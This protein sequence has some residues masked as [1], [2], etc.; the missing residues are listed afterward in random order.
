MRHFTCILALALLLTACGKGRQQA[1]MSF[2]ND[3]LLPVSPVKDQR[4]SDLCWAYAMLATIE[5]EHIAMGDSVNL[6]VDFVARHLLKELSF[7]YFLH[8]GD[9]DISLRGMAPRLIRRIMKDGLLSYDSY[10]STECNYGVLQRKLKKMADVAVSRR[11]PQ[12]LFEQKVEKMLDDEIRP[13]PR[14]QFM[15]GVEY[16]SHEFAHSVCLPDEY[17]A[18]TSMPHLLYGKQVVPDMP[19]NIDNDAFLNVPIDTLMAMVERSLRHG[20]PVCWEGDI[21]E[22]GFLFEQGIATTGGKPTTEQRKKMI[23]QHKTTDDHCMSIVG[24]AHDTEGIPYF[25]CKNSWGTNNPFGGLIYMSFNYFYLKT[26]AVV[27]PKNEAC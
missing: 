22:D 23:E 8:P 24:L 6:S 13:V 9:R 1:G 3:V 26:I 21:S 15:G 18:L 19:D 14:Y 11:M 25:I 5:T 2:E 7:D 27:L 10:H 4:G 17:A 20:H 16:T 12:I